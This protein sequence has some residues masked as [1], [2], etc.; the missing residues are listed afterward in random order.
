MKVLLVDNYDSFTFNLVHYITSFDVQCDVIRNDELNM[1][2]LSEYDRIVISPGPGLPGDTKNLLEL[3]TSVPV[4]TPILG[5]C[6]GLQ[7]IT[8]YFGGNLINQPEVKH[9]VQTRLQILKKGKLFTELPKNFKVGLYH[10]WMVNKETLPECLSITSLSAE[11]VIM[12]LEHNTLP[13]VGVQF[14]PESILSENGKK[15]ISN[16]LFAT[17]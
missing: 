4:D 13:I 9:G 7:A 2:Q 12:S 3:F 16:F 17:W 10:S 5:V 14:H 8:T 6:L 15:I 1:N 11:G